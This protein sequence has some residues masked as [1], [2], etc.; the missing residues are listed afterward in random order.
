MISV[1][2]MH[3]KMARKIQQEIMTVS[4]SRTTLLIVQDYILG[5]FQHQ[6]MSQKALTVATRKLGTGLVRQ[7]EA[8]LEAE[9]IMKV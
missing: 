8:I 3:G 2:Q 9:A 4:M 7:E 5:L 1:V 6:I